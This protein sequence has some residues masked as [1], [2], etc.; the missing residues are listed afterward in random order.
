MLEPH[1]RSLL[2][3][4][5]QPPRGYQLVQAVG[6]TFTLDLA[7]ALTIPLS[8]A[9]RNL[10]DHDDLGIIA[11]LAQYTDRIS[12]FTQAGEIRAGVRSDLL[13]LLEDVVHPVHP[14]RGIFHPKVWLLEYAAGVKRT[15]RFLCL[16]RNLTEDRSWDLSVRLDGTPAQE[17]HVSAARE[18]NQPLVDFLHHLP[19]LVI[20]PLAV[21]RARSIAEFAERI[22]DVKWEPPAGV[23]D[24]RFHFLKGSDRDHSS[25]VGETGPKD[26]VSEMLR[27]R[28]G[29]ALII[30]PFVSPE[31]LATV[32]E[33][34]ARNIRLIS[35]PESLERLPSEVLHTLAE[36]YVLD[37]LLA[38]TEEE[39]AGMLSGLHAK[40]IFLSERR[41]PSRA[42]ALIGSANV[43][44]GGLRNNIEMMVELQG[45][46][47][48]LGPSGVF[49]AL[50]AMLEQH[51]PTG[52][53]VADETETVR[54]S[55]EARLR[56]LAA[57]RFFARIVEQEPYVMRVWC[58]S[59]TESSLGRMRD[60]FIELTWRLLSKA[61]G[62]G[63]LVAGE[64][65]A[66]EISGLRLIEI[67]PFLQITAAQQ[68]Q[69]QRV[70]VSTVVPAEL[71]D[72]VPGRQDAL[73]AHGVTHGEAF[74]R[75]LALLLDPDGFDLDLGSSSA[76]SG[77][78]SWSMDIMTRGLFE[79]L[80]KS[81]ARGD[82]GI[83]V[84][85]RILNGLRKSSGEDTEL[86]EEFE[87]LWRNVLKVRSTQRR[88]AKP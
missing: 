22:T 12:I 85:Q 5:L 62:G 46:S 38:L 45:H 39:D 52:G 41:R 20:H 28:A 76:G 15:F 50:G 74:L 47:R 16:S 21:K 61:V 82:D 32:N 7:T 17:E 51:L 19:T 48:D 33:R 34:V 58:D 37:D 86:P 73:L 64:D 68:V 54:H 59:E 77:A 60:D 81:L 57:G 11:A 69:G 79:S 26:A 27:V 83:D 55:L 14:P 88:G 71:L 8:F 6:T 24:V 2:T 30:S 78:G 9:S 72:D 40:A 35:R 63:A 67:T 4:Q 42:H 84:A 65:E 66:A 36:T 87:D 56:A 31:G 1:N 18:L 49:D 29:E 44:A 3:D 80:L 53:Q 43:T 25:I 75:L 13:T 23:T 10:A 70:A